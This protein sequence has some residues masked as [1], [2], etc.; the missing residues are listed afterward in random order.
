MVLIALILRLIVVGFLYPERLNPDRDHWRFAGETGRIAR[1]IVEGKGF[2]NPLFGDTGPTAWMTPIYPYLVA[3]S[4]RFF[5][6][7]SRASAIAM[8][9]LN[10]VFSALT[11]LPIF[12]MARR[13]FG[14]V[15]ACRAGW[16]WA[17]FPYA[18]YFSGDFIWS[19][20]LTTF[21]LALAFALGLR[22]EQ[23]KRIRDWLA[24]GIVAGIAALSDPVVLS[25]LPLLGLWM[26]CRSSR[27]DGNWLL[28]GAAAGLAFIIV[29]TPWFVRNY[30]VFGTMIPFRDNF[31]LELYVGNHGETWHFAEGPHPSNSDEEWQEYRQL[32]EPRYMQRK[33]AQAVKLISQN[34]GGFLWLN[35]RRALYVWTNYW[36]LSR[37]Y[38]QAEPFDLPAI[39]LTTTL[40][41]LAL[42]GL[43]MGWRYLGTSVIPYAIALFFFPS[44]YYVT[45]LEDYYRRPADPFYV[46]LAVHAVTAC[47]QRRQQRT[48]HNASLAQPQI[49]S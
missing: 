47:L 5:G 17:F 13:T 23:S 32:G 12:F 33:Q 14:E 10:G 2:G 6:V 11:C 48:N 4:F 24:F 3:L 45:H 15:V 38:R 46:V 18:I 19:T 25:V 1:S 27:R 44:V 20:V 43:W 28:R 34:K 9:S 21:L 49:V 29:V 26:W 31:G 22:L 41:V 36:S 7:Y 35:F 42:C 30:R 16:T 8:L 40:S 39:L 37:R